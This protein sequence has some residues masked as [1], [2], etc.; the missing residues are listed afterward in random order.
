[1]KI[2]QPRKPETR[3]KVNFFFERAKFCQKIQLVKL[4]KKLRKANFLGQTLT[5]II[6][7]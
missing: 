6:E 2:Q 4:A 3:T 7:K 5:Q 1:M